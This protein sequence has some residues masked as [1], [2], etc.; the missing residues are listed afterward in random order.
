MSEKVLITSA[1]PYVNG[2]PH[3]GHL[4]GCLLPSD[5]FARYNRLIGKKVLCIGGADEYGSPSEIAALK[6]GIDVRTYVD[7]YF[8]IHKETSE[9]FN[10]SFD[11]FGRTSTLEHTEIVQKVYL[12]LKEN[13]FIEQ[14]E[15]EQIYSVDD[16]MF[17][18]D[19]YVE[20]VCPKCGYEK[21]RGDQCDKCGVIL[22]P[23]DLINPYSVISGSHNLEIRKTLHAFL[24]LKDMQ[25]L[26]ENWIKSRKGWSKVALSIANAWLKEGLQDRGI[27][28]DNKWGVPV[29]DMEGKVFYVWFDA[30]WGYVSISQEWAKENN[31]SWEEFWFGDDVKYYQFMGKDNVPFHSVFFPAEQ[32][33]TKENWKTVDV[34]KGIN[35]LNFG[36]G[37]FSKSLG[38]GFSGLDAIN[39]YMADYWR[40]WLM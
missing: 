39:L 23:V 11:K 12:E 14:K 15:T 21:A 4:V 25:G 20:G 32:L 30:P 36:D 6:E 38:N 33:G 26:V 37:K 3:L 13:G 27:T 35:F 16:D 31:T 19:R 8:N 22:D 1:L 29:P 24:K 5:I 18:A 17:L 40:Y 7:K 9:K 10:L 28:R 2:V 34:L